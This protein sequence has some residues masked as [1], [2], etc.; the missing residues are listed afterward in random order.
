MRLAILLAAALPLLA[1]CQGAAQ[2]VA[3]MPAARLPGPESPPAGRWR[4][5]LHWLPVG[6]RLIQAR[7]CRPERAGAAPLVVISH[8]SPPSAARRPGMR[9]GDCEAPAVAWFLARGQAVL[10]PLRRG[11]GASGGAWSEGFGPCQDAQF[12]RA[13]RETARD[14][15][16]AIA[17][18]ATLPGIRADRVLVVGLSAG[19]WGGLA[20]AAENPPQVAAVV[21]MAGG[22]GGWAQGAPNTN[23]RPDRLVSGAAEYGASARLPTLWIYAANDSFFAPDLVARMHAAYVGAGGAAELRALG[24]FGRD[25]HLLFGAAGGEAV[26]GPVLAEWLAARGL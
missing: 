24:P 15:A 12:A 1:A 26:W 11:Y 2:P 22:R 25:G 21:N 8:G 3:A 5:Q 7:L 9:P 20:L 23:C 4:E 16:A 13:G 18:A 6:D 14:T 19:G 17:Y 10:L